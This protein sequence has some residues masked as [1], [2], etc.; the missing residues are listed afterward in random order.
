MKKALLLS[1]AVLTA[2]PVLTLDATSAS[3]RPPAYRPYRGHP[4]GGGYRPVLRYRPAYVPV[5]RPRFGPVLVMPPPPPVVYYQP[6][7]PA[8]VVVVRESAPPPVVREAPA[9][10]VIA[11]PPAPVPSEPE[12]RDFLGVGLH[13]MGATAEGEK[14]GLSTAENPSMGGVGF[15]IRGRFS[16]DF[17]LELSA[18]FLKGSASNKD[19]T[20][21]TIPVMAGLTWHILPTSRFQPYLIAGLGVHFTRL[22]YFGGDYNI[23]LTELAGQ[24]GGGVELFL[25]ENIALH[26]DIRMQSVFKNLDTKEK[27]AQDCIS[28]VG[29]QTGFCDNIHSTS[30]DD[31]VD[32]GVSLSAGLSWYF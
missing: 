17:G 18:D 20:Q 25:T 24:L 5:Y 10:T 29:T 14:V 26:A 7:P 8:R 27:I 19:L 13:V 3:A 23:D 28:Q 11:Q 32:L 30:A 12:T 4:H 21:S 31:K 22:E 16:E 2:A 9:P 15:H 6:P 1:L